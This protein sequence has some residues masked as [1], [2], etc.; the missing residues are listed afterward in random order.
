MLARIPAG[1]QPGQLRFQQ[2]LPT[3]VGLLVRV[4]LSR[5]GLDRL[6]ALETGKRVRLASFTGGQAGFGLTAGSFL[7]EP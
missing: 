2:G 5:G 1:K 6:F 4:G 7:L 3:P